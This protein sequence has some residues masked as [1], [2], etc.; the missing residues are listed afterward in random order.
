MVNVVL[1]VWLPREVEK[2]LRIHWKN[3]FDDNSDAQRSHELH[4]TIIPKEKVK[5]NQISWNLNERTSHWHCN[6]VCWPCNNVKKTRTKGSNWMKI[7]GSISFAYFFFS[8]FFSPSF[9]PLAQ[10]QIFYGK[11]WTIPWYYFNVLTADESNDRCY[12]YIIMSILSNPVNVFCKETLN[13]RVSHL[14]SPW[15]NNTVKFTEIKANTH[16]MFLNVTG[17]WYML[18]YFGIIDH[19]KSTCRL[20]RKDNDTFHN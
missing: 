1:S 20:V 8:F 9:F 10:W 3:K 12:L 4:L 5:V 16:E 15:T 18:L 6:H 11:R 7:L 17:E 14:I 13:S 2:S 19:Q